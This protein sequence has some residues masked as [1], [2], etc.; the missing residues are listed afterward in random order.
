MMVAT[1]WKA[2]RRADGRLGAARQ[3][4]NSPRVTTAGGSVLPR[5]CHR[6]VGGTPLM[7]QSITLSTGLV[8][9]GNVSRASLGSA[10]WLGGYLVPVG[11]WLDNHQTVSAPR[12]WSFPTP[13]RLRIQRPPPKTPKPLTFK[14][15]I[16]STPSSASSFQP[17]L[18]LPANP[19]CQTKMVASCLLSFSRRHST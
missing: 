17:S 9:G 18:L 14:P 4:L 19:S 3:W 8:P 7:P 5:R 12:I 11:M 16:P 1:G 10:S 15:P 6:G 2:Q 13:S